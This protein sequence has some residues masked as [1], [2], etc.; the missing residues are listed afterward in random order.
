MVCVGIYVTSQAFNRAVEHNTARDQARTTQLL[1]PV[2]QPKLETVRG[3][4]LVEQVAEFDSSTLEQLERTDRPPDPVAAERLRNSVINCDVQ[5]LFVDQYLDGVE[6]QGV[7]TDAFDRRCMMLAI[8]EPGVALMHATLNTTMVDVPA[9]A[10]P[11]NP[12]V[13]LF[14]PWSS[15]IDGGVYLRDS[16]RASDGPT[17]VFSSV[18]CLSDWFEV[19]D[20]IVRMMAGGLTRQRDP[21]HDRLFHGRGVRRLAPGRD[22]LNREWAGGRSC[23]TTRRRF[24]LTRR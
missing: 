9:S 16:L 3:E 4:C 17:L 12:L 15:C 11:D 21:R 2:G 10:S 8:S 24:S 14:V 1:E 18:S 13:P 20:R 6:S 7:A 5:A 23:G 19:D 22:D